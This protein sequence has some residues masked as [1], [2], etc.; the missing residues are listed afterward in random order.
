MNVRFDR[1][2]RLALKASL[3]CARRLGADEMGGE[4]VLVGLANIPSRATSMLTE[5]GVE[6]S[7]LE[8]AVARGAH[9]ARLLAGLG[10]DLAAVQRQ[11][12]VGLGT[13][14]RTRR[15]RFR[16]DA[17]QAIESSLVQGRLD[18]ARRIRPEHLLLGLLDA[19]VAARELLV[20][21]GVD[22]LKLR[23]TI[24]HALGDGG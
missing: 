21:L 3:A 7:G 23:A 8:E 16:T 17:R 24:V 10:I 9:D 20:A 15:P 4:H 22:V 18:R 2:A 6:A 19:S 11:A 13:R 5:L 14:W 12:G 1:E